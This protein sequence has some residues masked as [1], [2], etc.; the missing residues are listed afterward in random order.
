MNT[1][2]GHDADHRWCPETPSRLRLMEEDERTSLELA[3]RLGLRSAKGWTPTIVRIS[4]PPPSR[5]KCVVCNSF[6]R[7]N[8]TSDVCSDKCLKRKNRRITGPDKWARMPIHKM[9][10][11]GLKIRS[12]MLSKMLRTTPG[13]KGLSTHLG[14]VHAELMRRGG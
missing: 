14:M 1:Q 11:R 3:R 6:M 4:P 12:G 7:A 2:L 9:T 10:D 13:D 5:K 8:Q